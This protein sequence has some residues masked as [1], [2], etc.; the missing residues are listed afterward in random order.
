M[1]KLALCRTR[2][3]IMLACDV[4]SR[5]SLS[6]G[7]AENGRKLADA[8]IRGLDICASFNIYHVTFSVATLTSGQY[9]FHPLGLETRLLSKLNCSGLRG[10]IG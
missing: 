3:I 7:T 9:D 1:I 4:G 8:I 10:P 5:T 2:A 6:R